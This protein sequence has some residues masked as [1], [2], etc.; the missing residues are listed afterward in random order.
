MSR[1]LG[2]NIK[3]FSGAGKTV[4]IP[5]RQLDNADIF[6]AHSEAELPKSASTSTLILFNK[7]IYVG[8]GFGIELLSAGAQVQD[9]NGKTVDLSEYLSQEDA[10]AKFVAKKDMAQYAKKNEVPSISGLLSK[11]EADES[12]VAKET[13]NQ[14]A[15]KVNSLP[16]Q[17][18]KGDKGD[19]GEPG[20]DAVVDMEAIKAALFETKAFVLRSDYENLMSRVEALEKKSTDISGDN[21]QVPEVKPEPEP[22]SEPS[23]SNNVFGVAFSRWNNTSDEEEFFHA[24]LLEE[25]D[26]YNLNIEGVKA[27]AEKIMGS[28][29]LSGYDGLEGYIIIGT[30]A[31]TYN[32][33]N[34]GKTGETHVGVLDNDMLGIPEKYKGRNFYCLHGT[35]SVD[36]AS[37]E[38]VSVNPIE[39]V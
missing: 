2:F 13:Y 32:T 38:T 10:N 23:N 11:T 9:E 4:V 20:K 18:V 5:H 12:Y 31:T 15:N 29:E 24:C 33:I 8:T 21:E 16:T 19:K 27:E 17:G 30:E 28:D 6:V 1:I 7:K 25:T 39:T 22:A 26:T 14:L 34:G 36:K 37:E 3:K 35:K